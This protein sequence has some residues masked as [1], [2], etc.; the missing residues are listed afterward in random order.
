MADNQFYKESLVTLHK[1]DYVIERENKRIHN[2]KSGLTMI[3]NSRCSVNKKGVSDGHYTVEF[4]ERQN[5]VTNNISFGEA[6]EY[7]LSKYFNEYMIDW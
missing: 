7:L 2:I 6:H 3:I 4:I 1:E 5:G